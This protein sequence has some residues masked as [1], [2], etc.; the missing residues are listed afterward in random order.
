M[1]KATPV[2][3]YRSKAA[4]CYALMES[5]VPFDEIGRLIGIPKNDARKFAYGY[6]KPLSMQTVQRDPTGPFT[7]APKRP[8]S[9]IDEIYEARQRAQARK[10]SRL[11]PTIHTT[12][13]LHG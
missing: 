12:P 8:S 11:S 6:A 5:G 10:L 7:Y 13:G 4:A 1:G 9:L 3:G 2:L